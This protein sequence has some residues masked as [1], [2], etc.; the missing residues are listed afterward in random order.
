MIGAVEGYYGPPLSPEQR[1]DLVAWLGPHGF[2]AYVYAPKDDPFHRGRWREPYPDEQMA[3]FAELVERGRAAGVEVGFAIS[4]GLDWRPGADEDALVA[5][6]TSFA[7]LGARTLAVA[8]DDVPPG[9]ADLGRAHGRAVAAAANAVD[10]RWLT[11][12]TD[13]AVSRPT[14]Y[15]R[16]F[17]DELPDEVILGWT[18]PSIVSPTLEADDVVTLS[19]ALGRTLLLCENFPVNDG[20]MSGVLHLGPYPVRDPKVVERTA[21]VLCNFGARPLSSRPGL[22]VAARFWTD[23]TADRERAWRE[24]IPEALM[25]LARACRSWVADPGPDRELTRLA[26][27]SP[28]ELRAYLDAGCRT[29]LDPDLAAEVEPWLAAWEL[30]AQVMRLCLDI[31]EDDS[32]R[33]DL[34]LIL[35]ELW[36]RARQLREQV[37]GI[38]MAGYPVT[39]QRGDHVEPGPGAVVV[40]ENLTD[41][42][43]ARTLRTHWK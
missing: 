43:C 35:I 16:A 18:G 10:A 31:F 39:V 3:H 2:D 8:F 9:G 14:T 19:E 17:C 38:R 4:P 34:T 23:P 37:F 13:Y 42:L 12:P 20:P 22:A 40:G 24:A 7:D 33:A 15:L 41:R 29:G 28:S 6:L 5:K 30:E 25:P 21:G 27:W 1:L 32:K 36:I 26:D 11:V